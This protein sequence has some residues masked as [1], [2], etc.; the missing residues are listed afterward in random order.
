MKVLLLLVVVIGCAVAEMCRS[1]SD[2]SHVQCDSSTQLHCVFNT[3]TCTEPS[4]HKC[5]TQRDC[6]YIRWDCPR[7]RRHCIDGLCKCT[8]I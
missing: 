4:T 5:Q 2:C 3:C 8:R 7:D 6:A 1:D